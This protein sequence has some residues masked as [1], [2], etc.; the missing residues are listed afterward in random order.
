M[1][2]MKLEKCKWKVREVGFLEVIIKPEEIN[3][4]EEKMK[5]VLDQPTPK[6]IKDIQKFLGLVNYYR[7]FIKDF[8][9]IARPLNDLVK[10]NQKWNQTEKQ[11]KTFKKL[12]K[13]FTKEL[14]LVAL[15][16]DLKNEDRSR[17]VR[18]YNRR[19]VING[20]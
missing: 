4:E 7:Q 13:R 15:D 2:Y 6:R 20:V 10:K 17:Y 9:S 1:I 3:M 5:K 19:S 8:T 18:L 12:K 16:L 14:V 11:E